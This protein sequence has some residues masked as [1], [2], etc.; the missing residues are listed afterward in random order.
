MVLRFSSYR[1]VYGNRSVIQGIELIE[2][3]KKS[4][5]HSKVVRISPC[6]GE[7]FPPSSCIGAW[8]T[9]V[10]KP[11]RRGLGRGRRLLRNTADQERLRCESRP[12]R[13]NRRDRKFGFGR[14]GT[15]GNR[16]ENLRRAGRERGFRSLSDGRLGKRRI[17]RNH[18][19]T[20]QNENEKRRE[21]SRRFFHAGIFRFA[22]SG[23]ARAEDGKAGFRG[24]TYW[25]GSGLRRKAR[26][27]S[28]RRK[29]RERGREWRR[30]TIT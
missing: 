23:F 7:P 17:T 21:E 22:P 18:R 28:Q 11:K 10:K 24:R 19:S 25:K 30:R 8:P 27:A 13:R 20:D 3:Q 14:S 4:A 2:E 1:G 29:E 16:R 12:E 5:R 9:A 26:I 15:G 6:R